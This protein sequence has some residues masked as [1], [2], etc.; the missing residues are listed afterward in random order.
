MNTSPSVFSPLRHYTSVVLKQEK[1]PRE[2]DTK[3]ERESAAQRRASAKSHYSP[4]ER[5]TRELFPNT[6]LCV[7][8][9]ISECNIGHVWSP[10]RVLPSQDWRASW[11]A[12]RSRDHPNPLCWLKL[13]PKMSKSRGKSSSLPPWKLCRRYTEKLPFIYLK[14]ILKLLFILSRLPFRQENHQWHPFHLR[15]H[16]VTPTTNTTST[17]LVAT[18]APIEAAMGARCPP[19]RLWAAAEVHLVS[20]KA[21]TAH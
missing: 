12:T 8:K 1:K 18:W 6:T 9:K 20:V 11:K 21:L 17:S 15:L 19:A 3:N 7:L 2:E 4:W 13:L 16:N 5:Q 10:C 14:D